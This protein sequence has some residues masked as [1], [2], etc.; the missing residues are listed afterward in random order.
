M[1]ELWTD[2]IEHCTKKT[3]QD[4]PMWIEIKELFDKSGKM[5]PEDLYKELHSTGLRHPDLNNL[6]KRAI[7]ERCKEDEI[8]IMDVEELVRFKRRWDNRWGK[9]GDDILQVVRKIKK[10]GFYGSE[11]FAQMMDDSFTEACGPEPDKGR[12]RRLFPDLLNVETVNDKAVALAAIYAT[13]EDENNESLNMGGGL[14]AKFQETLKPIHYVSFR[15]DCDS[16]HV[17]DKQELDEILQWVDEVSTACNPASPAPPAPTGTSEK[18]SKPKRAEAKE[19]S[20]SDVIILEA[21]KDHHK[22]EPPPGSRPEP[23]VGNYSPATLN[24]LAKRSKC[25]KPTISRYLKV[26]FGGFKAYCGICDTGDEIAQALMIRS[27]M[28]PKAVLRQRQLK[29]DP[30]TH[31][32]EPK[33]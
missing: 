2:Y 4:H 28:P 29:R 10:A 11:K 3:P 9:D 33:D 23:T 6:P 32:P 30:E 16:I 12:F 25:S 26:Q 7:A 24:D 17:I 27:G 19:E 1:S 14:R 8:L 21:L 5:S 22:Y 18:T 13:Y 31:D 20:R 15:L